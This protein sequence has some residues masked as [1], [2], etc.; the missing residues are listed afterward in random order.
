VAVGR[1]T[2][3]FDFSLHARRLCEDMAARLP[4]LAHVRMAQVAVGFSQTRS[5]SA[6]GTFATLTPLRFAGGAAE[7]MRRGRPYRVQRLYDRAGTEMLYILSFFLPRFLELDFRRKLVTTAHELWH[8]GPLFDG[9]VRRFEGR[10]YAHSASKRQFDQLAEALADR[11][12]AARPPEEVLGFLRLSYRTLL[13][14]FGRIYGLKIRN[15]KL[16]PM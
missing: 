6:Y 10:C 1:T 4:E 5:A 11:Y 7:T 8:I 16:L 9:D 14:R 15:P 12:L 13:N 2:A 3:G